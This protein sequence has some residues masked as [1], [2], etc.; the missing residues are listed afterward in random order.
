VG[1]KL[2]FLGVETGA[3]VPEWIWFSAACDMRS[4]RV[5]SAV[6]GKIKVD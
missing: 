4:F 3:S 5:D 6:T 1:V 2:R